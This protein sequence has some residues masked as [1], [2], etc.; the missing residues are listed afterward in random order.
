MSVSVGLRARIAVY[1]VAALGIAACQRTPIKRGEDTGA[2][3]EAN[4][5]AV[6][7]FKP[8]SEAME[9]TLAKN[10]EDLITRQRLLIL[11]TT[12][13]D[14]VIGQQATIEARR[15]H[16]LWLIQHHPEHRGARARQ[17]WILTQ[18]GDADPDPAGY[19]EGRKLWLAQV[20]RPDAPISFL[21]GAARYFRQNDKPLAETM[22]LRA[23]LIEPKG[24]WSIELGR[25]YYEILVGAKSTGSDGTVASVSAAEAHS[26]YATRIRRKLDES[27]DATLLT[28]AA[29]SL[30][31]QGPALY[32]NHRIDF[33]PVALAMTYLGKAVQLDPQST[34]A[35]QVAL[36]I[37]F[38]ERGGISPG[39]PKGSSPQARYDM[40]ESQ[41]EAQRLLAMS[42]L[43][44]AVVVNS[45][46]A[47][48]K[49]DAAQASA[50]A[51]IARR[52]AEEALR[53][54]AKFPND[55]DCGT[56][57]Y[58]AN[59]V[60]GLLALRGR[61]RKVAIQFM[62]D[63]SQAPPTEEL[64]Y[65]MSDFSL[66]LPERLFQDGQRDAVVQFLERFARGNVS[67]KGYLLESAK[68]IRSGKKPLWVLK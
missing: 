38:K 58:N 29:D 55:P 30:G 4:Q 14:K 22:L 45:E 66:M 11:Y 13:G 28:T 5:K 34:P 23:R 18:P 32:E 7:D 47:A 2:A 16:I 10:P 6:S 59:M 3:Q 25:L 65:S 53:L 24:H 21:N 9:A 52:A 43:A 44:E 46:E 68:A 33:D 31:L 40:V 26:P 49:H 42:L 54:A 37:R 20:E 8:Q 51:E 67:S 27:V 19:Q 63:A 35:H 36:N 17:A 61:D 62:L 12:L 56:A 41:P 39:I 60:L 1:V 57:I 48:A 64:A 50:S 15:R